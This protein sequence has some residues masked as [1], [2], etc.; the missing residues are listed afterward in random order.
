MSKDSEETLRAY[1]ENVLRLQQERQQQLS[2]EELRQIALDTGMSD[3]DLAYIQTQFEGFLARG[4]GFLR[5][6]NWNAAIPELLQAV[7][8]SPN[9]TDALTT[10]AEAH[11]GRWH[12][13]HE[14]EDREKVTLYAER[15]LMIDPANDTAL[16][17]LSTLDRASAPRAAA[18]TLA[19]TSPRRAVLGLIV[20]MI[21]IVTLGIGGALYVVFR[22]APKTLPHITRFP[23][24][25]PSVSPQPKPPSSFTDDD[26]NETSDIATLT[27]TIGGEGIGPGLMKDARSIAIDGDGYIYTAEYT[28]PRIQRFDPSGKFVSQF[29]LD[30]KSS[31]IKNI[32]ADN[33]GHLYLTMQGEIGIFN[34]T[35]GEQTG[36]LSYKRGKGFTS[37]AATPNGGIMGLWDFFGAKSGVFTNVHA[38]NELVEFNASGKVVRVLKDAVTNAT[39]AVM[40]H[41]DIALDGLGN[42]YLYG[43]SVDK[44]A[45]LSPTG[46]LLDRIGGSKDGSTVRVE[47]VGVDG[48][49]RIYVGGSR[50]ISV[51]TSDGG[52]V[53]TFKCDGY[54]DDIAINRDGD[55]FIAART[56]VMKYRLKKP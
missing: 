46:K 26:P 16:R 36:T 44:L 49:G 31:Y 45:K 48:Q 13:S 14:E 25:S 2:D 15:C 54:P 50:T 11:W 9:S 30:G 33:Q 47:A 7:A 1:M 5:Y 40:P 39:D 38:D 55:I 28:P 6:K 35:T 23:S 37:I 18:G 52:V 29:T 8:L 17:L 43:S 27:Q 51:Y 53:G 34:G 4:K 32:V 19:G 12:E 3:D 24:P 22:S 41:C 56:K 20:G 21:A 10:I 42:I